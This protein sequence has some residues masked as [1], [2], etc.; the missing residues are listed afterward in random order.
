MKWPRSHDR[1]LKAHRS[2]LSAT[3]RSF[4]RLHLMTSCPALYRVHLFYL[5]CDLA[6]LKM[7]AVSSIISIFLGSRFVCLLLW[8]TGVFMGWSHFA[9]ISFAQPPRGTRTRRR[10]RKRQE[11]AGGRGDVEQERFSNESCASKKCEQR[12]AG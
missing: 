9:S 3:A 4:R 12:G 10:K 2:P 11:E 6:G 5:F 7:R 8:L 1:I